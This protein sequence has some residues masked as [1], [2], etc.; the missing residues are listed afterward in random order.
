MK[1]ETYQDT[2]GEWRWTLV[3]AN[4][5]KIADG[6]EG[7]TREADVER[8]VTMVKEGVYGMVM[9]EVNGDLELDGPDL[10]E[11]ET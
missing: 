1:F 7:Y 6:S 10:L 9:L 5:E 11:D 4:G 8:A 2:A 3:A